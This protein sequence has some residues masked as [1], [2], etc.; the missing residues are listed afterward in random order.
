MVKHYMEIKVTIGP[1]EIITLNFDSYGLDQKLPNK[2]IVILAKA[3]NIR[4]KYLD[5]I[6]F[7]EDISNTIKSRPIDE[8]KINC[9]LIYECEYSEKTE[10]IIDYIKRRKN[11]IKDLF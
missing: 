9:I 7:L 4:F 6:G 11:I 1:S 3:D 5:C 2:G 8:K 10:S